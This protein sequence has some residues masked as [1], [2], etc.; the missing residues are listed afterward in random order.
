MSFRKASATP[1]MTSIV[2][3]AAR[4]LLDRVLHPRM[5]ASR[6]YDLWSSTY[7]EQDDNVLLFLD[8]QLLTTF[9]RFVPL[10]D[11]VIVD[12][13]CGTGRHWPRLLARQPTRV[14]GFD[15]SLGMLARLQQK[16]P[17][18]EAHAV[19]D[20]RLRELSDKSADVVIST[21]TLG[22]LRDADAALREWSRVLKPGG[23]IILTDFHPVAASMGT[24][25]F[26]LQDK[27]VHIRHYA[28]PLASLRASAARHDL[29]VV[30]F[31]EKL[32]DDS[33]RDF[34]ESQGAGPL[35]VRLK[36]SPLMYGMQL[37]K[38]SPG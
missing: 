32:V 19:H 12:V 18:A 25:C 35:F 9:L 23:Q 11:K 24:R 3:R 14:I 22:Y 37:A 10:K 8:E 15:A 1:L 4:Y 26:R 17:K 36:G 21:L 31:E 13:G 16:F 34:Y 29:R 20:H 38:G 27:A 7:D 33:V 6:A 2:R 30:R 5:N 28:H